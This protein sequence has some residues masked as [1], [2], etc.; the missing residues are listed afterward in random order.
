[1]ANIEVSVLA[2]AGFEPFAASAF[3][4]LSLGKGVHA[5]TLYQKRQMRAFEDG[6]DWLRGQDL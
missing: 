1:M 3:P 6:E 4:P 2:A 5:S